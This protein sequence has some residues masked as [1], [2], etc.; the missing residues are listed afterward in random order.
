VSTSPI[1]RRVVTLEQALV[2][3]AQAQAHTDANLD[4]LSAEMREFKQEMREFK[5]EMLGFKDRTERVIERLEQG[6]ERSRRQWGELANKMGTLVEDIVLP[7]IPEVFSRLF[8]LEPNLAVRVR[9]QHPIERGRTREFDALAQA[10][11]V[12][13]VNQT[14]STLRPGDI[15]AFVELLRGEAREYLPQARG[16]KLVGA[17]ASF[18]VD[19]SLVR[20]AERQG[21]IVL[22]LA[23]GIVEVLNREGFRPAEF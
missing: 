7:G 15:E 1:E 22:G 10:G 11:D 23:R 4:R 9:L 5:Q 3:L 12:L 16:L 19:P 2:D 21:L 14:K 8:G 20:A 6:D 13:M 17:L 18:Y